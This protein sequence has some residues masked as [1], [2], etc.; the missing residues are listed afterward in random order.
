M[1]TYDELVTASEPPQR[2]RHGLLALEKELADH[3]VVSSS[4]D[5]AVTV[6][7]TGSGELLEITV[8]DLLLR[9]PH[10][11]QVGPAILATVHAARLDAARYSRD[12]CQLVL[13]P[14]AHR[15]TAALPSVP[16]PPPSINRPAPTPRAV[17][18]DD[19]DDLF[20]GFGSR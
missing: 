9:G 8:L 5:G 13:D 2:I 16:P 12:Q 7:V 11:Q 3:R 15:T 18:D 1:S 17:V 10:P 14:D 20:Q 19:G 4:P 6:T